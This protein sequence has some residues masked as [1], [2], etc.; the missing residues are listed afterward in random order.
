MR[1]LGRLAL[2]VA[3]SVAAWC[4]IPLKGDSGSALGAT[5][6]DEIVEVVADPCGCD[7]DFNSKVEAAN[8]IYAGIENAAQ[9]AFFAEEIR[10]NAVMQ[11]VGNDPNATEVELLAAVANYDAGCN[12]AQIVYF[13]VVAAAAYVLLQLVAQAIA[14]LLLCRAV[15]AFLS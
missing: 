14:E 15:C 11:A 8:A 6:E 7:Q 10:L 13:A 4:V 3:V 12:A 1:I 9:A 2:V 5:V